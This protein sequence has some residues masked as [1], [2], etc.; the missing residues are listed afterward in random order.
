MTLG[1][2]TSG[3]QIPVKRFMAAILLFSP[4]FAWFYLMNDLIYEFSVGIVP[5]TQEW[6]YIGEALYLLS[7]LGSAIIGSMISERLNCR[8]FLGIWIIFGV[9]TTTS[10]AVFQD[11]TLFI[12]LSILAG[13]SFGIG[14][15]S[16]LAFVTNSTVVEERAR[17]SGA[18]MLV[19]FVAI[20]F[21]RVILSP[22]ELIDALIL[23]AIFRAISFFAVLIDPCERA[24]GKKK[25]W[26]A[27][28]T[29]NGFGLYFIS[30]LM[31]WAAGG[32]TA[33]VGSWL[34]ASAEWEAV[35]S[36][37]LALNTVVGVGVFGF[38]SGFASD[39]FGRKK[40]IM[41]GLCSL[42][43]SYMVF[44]VTLLDITYY[45]TQI[46]FGASYGIMFSIFFMTV[47]GDLASNSSKERYYAAGS[48]FLIL[49]SS[50]Q[51]LATILG[52]TVESSVVS[53]ILG[54]VLFVAVLPLLYAPETLPRDKIRARKFKKYL[55]KVKKL[56]EEEETQNHE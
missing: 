53:S 7:I 43:I 13:A 45:L 39:F 26:K 1:F 54:I 31:F 55:K 33:F 42:G 34:P 46:F 30:W 49:P 11:P 5:Q 6:V 2:L 21:M 16:C 47:L 37:G 9:L 24:L 23:T 56:V 40:I 36:L 20:M 10:F 3:F 25:T 4:T 35:E 28:F 38:L 22:F 12:L 50:I 48:I 51:L 19:T 32:L 14:F 8:R 52:I 15:P 29:T 18:A 17:V 27:V 44:G 41:F